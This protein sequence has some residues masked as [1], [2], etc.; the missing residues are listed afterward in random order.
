MTSLFISYSRKDIEAARKLTKAFHGQGLDFWID[1]EGI[2][3]T[4]DWWR[5]IERGIEQ[6]NIFLFL[7]SPDSAAS[8]VCRQEIE[9]AAKNGKRLIPVVV[10]D[11][12]A[13]E[14]PAELKSLNWIFLREHDDFD[15]NFG[16]LITAIKTDYEWVQAHC[17][18][19]IKAREWERN[20]R[21]DGFLLH[22]KELQDAEI[23]LVANSAKEPHPT[24]LQ[25]DYVLKSRQVTDRQRRKLTS[26]TV[27]GLIIV[28]ALAVYGFMQAGLARDAQA[29]AEANAASAQTAQANAES[30]E[31][32]RATAQAQAEERAIVARAGELAAQSISLQDRNFQ[33]SLLL[34]IEGCYLLDDVQTRGALLDNIRANPQL[35]Q[36]IAGHSNWVNSVAFSPDGRLLA[37]GSNDNTIILWDVATG[38]PVGQP[39]KGHSDFVES[40]AFSPDSK[41]LVSGGGDNQIIVWN[42]TTGQPIGKPLT[43]HS[44]HIN[45]VAYSPNGKLIASGGNDGK[46]ILWN[47]ITRQPVG[48]PLVSEESGWVMSLAFSPDSKTIAS[49]S[50]NSNSFVFA[51]TRQPFATFWNVATNQYGRY[52]L[53]QIPEAGDRESIL[54]P[55]GVVFDVIFSPDGKT[56]AAGTSDGVIILWDVR[57]RRSIGQPLTSHTGPITL[58]FSSDGKT[59][60]SASD[61]GS[62]ILWDVTTGQP[63]GKPMNGHSGAV[64]SIAFSPDGETLVSGGKDGSI[65]LWD[66]SNAINAN[67][68]TSYPIGKSVTSVYSSNFSMAFSPD[69]KT[70]ASGN[71]FAI[72]FWDIT[73]DPLDRQSTAGE[74]NLGEVHSVAFS[75]D[76][77]TFASADNQVM[78]WDATTWKPIMEPFAGHSDTVNSVAFSPDSA[79]LA[80]AS[81]DGTIILMDVMTHQ[82]IGSPIT[83]HL[84]PVNSVAFS[85]DSKTLAS[86]GDDNSVILWDVSDLANSKMTTIFSAEK[87]N[88]GHSG[89]VNSVAFSPN[90]KILASG[91]DDKLIF[92]W[93]IFTGQPIGHPLTGHLEKVTGV[94]F[95][96]DGKTLASVSVDKTVILW[97]VKTG[98]PIGQP[99]RGSQY[100]L[101]GI[102]FTPDSKTLASGGASDEVMIWDIDPQSWIEKACQRAGR[103]FTQA[104]WAQY[105]PDEDYRVTCTQWPAGE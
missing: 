86:G 76:G 8:K 65:I 38:E 81:D 57:N 5:E 92:L 28:A 23:Q 55:Y 56:L 3:P 66:V 4:V 20:N 10:R 83:G 53:V 6:A 30:N 59:L 71:I 40:L 99:I 47:A 78:L 2:P 19:Q 33:N 58:A 89:P 26:A 82:P 90:G 22:G 97:D 62:I 95:S 45:R 96:P 105:F 67:L 17:Q 34:G 43:G 31:N 9:H 39:F 42:V 94:A 104:E 29:I 84:G 73:A 7:L 100:P 14:S 12:K 18:L 102:A 48:E 60:A 27:A 25:R 21:E 11:I 50:Y 44:S 93:N 72:S 103:N 1:W 101:Y 24:D 35:R 61:D 87:A 63:L 15:T 13:D 70:L 37:S 16:K 91:S 32:A 41:T 46:I 36:I 51:V 79:I 68:I 69:G 75:P 88:S 85:P 77:K 54:S 74:V 52:P 98:K 64:L 80:S 49:V